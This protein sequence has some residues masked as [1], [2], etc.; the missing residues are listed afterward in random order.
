MIG[1]CSSRCRERACLLV[2]DPATGLDHR[3]AADCSGWRSAGHHSLDR[4]GADQPDVRGRGRDRGGAAVLPFEGLPGEDRRPWR[5]VSRPSPRACGRP[6]AQPA[7]AGA[8]AVLWTRVALPGGVECRFYRGPVPA[9]GITD[10][11]LVPSRP[12]ACEEY[13]SSIA[14]VSASGGPRPG[15]MLSRPLS[16]PGRRW[17]PGAARWRHGRHITRAHT[18]RPCLRAGVEA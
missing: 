14:K 8:F 10:D 13:R 17:P 7:C 4:D 2:V 11:S 3:A 5:P 6:S 9:A 16:S 15:A 12:G 18:S 1:R